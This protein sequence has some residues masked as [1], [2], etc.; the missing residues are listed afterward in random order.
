ME[1]I[2]A[3][4]AFFTAMRP[5]GTAGHEDQAADLNQKRANGR[6]DRAASGKL[7]AGLDQKQKRSGANPELRIWTTKGGRV[8]AKGRN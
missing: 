3:Q 7:T 2:T 6:K 1:N 8:G 5:E 4:C